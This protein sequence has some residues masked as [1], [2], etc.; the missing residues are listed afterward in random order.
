MPSVHVSCSRVR[1]LMTV[2]ICS[3]I[4]VLTTVTTVTTALVLGA[5]SVE[6]GVWRI[7]LLSVGKWCAGRAVANLHTVTPRSPLSPRYHYPRLHCPQSL[8]S[9]YCLHCRH[10]TT[11]TIVT[12]VTTD[13]TV[14][15]VTLSPLSPLSSW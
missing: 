11:F 13:S 2:F 7:H 6:C 5:G 3:C 14:A 9:H 15:M 4:H 8:Q 12:T 10:V 1:V